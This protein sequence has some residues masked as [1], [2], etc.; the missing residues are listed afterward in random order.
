MR[1]LF[2]K[3]LLPG[4]LLVLLVA[5]AGLLLASRLP[6]PGAVTMAILAG[7]LVENLF[8]K[9]LEAAAAGVLFSEKTLLPVAIA[10]LGVRLDGRQLLELGLPTVGLVLAVVA[11]ALLLAAGLGRLF[12]ISWTLS[13]CM[14]AGNGVCGSSA[15]AAVAPVIDAS[16]EETGLSIAT[17]NLLG[18]FG[19]FLLPPLAAWLALSV[20]QTGAWIGGSLQAVGQVVAAGYAAGETTGTLAV[21]VKMGRVLM[22][23]PVALCLGLLARRSRTG[24]DAETAKPRLPVP[25]FILAF[26]AFSLLR[27]IG[28]LPENLADALAWAGKH[29]LIVAMAGI[30]LRIR[31]A[32]LRREGPRVLLLG[33]AVAL[34]QTLAVLGLALLLF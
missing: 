7:I 8:H 27:T 18:T 19:I 23:G 25:L 33:T 20:P 5:G 11:L 1:T 24:T 34:L 9:R 32:A 3:N 28:L 2:S 29:L 6:G 15:I 22:I 31:F 14:G 12:G 26:F 17:V 4:L 21:L 10:L 16:E 13:L 30:G